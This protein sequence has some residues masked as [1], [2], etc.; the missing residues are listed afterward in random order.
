MNNPEQSKA[1]RREATKM[2]NEVQR[3][4]E[5][6]KLAKFR[7]YISPITGGVRAAMAILDDRWVC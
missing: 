4:H 3:K 2:R 5:A 6:E 7:L 1:I